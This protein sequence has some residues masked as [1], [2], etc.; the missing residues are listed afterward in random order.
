MLQIKALDHIIIGDNDYFS[1]LD[2]GLPP[3]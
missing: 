1:F 2:E 3:F